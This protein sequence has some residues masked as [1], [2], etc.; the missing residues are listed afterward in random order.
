M[1]LFATMIAGASL[2]AMMLPLPAAAETTLNLTF[3]ANQNDEDYDGAMVFKNYVETNTNGSV[4]VDVFAGAQLCGSAV[5]CFESLKAGVVDIYNGTAGGAAVIYP[6][7]QA[8]DIPYLFS[9]DRVVMDV[10]R[11]PL[12][13]QIRERVLEATNNEIMLLAIGQTGGWRG[14]GTTKKQVKTPADM[15]G[16]KIRTIES[17]IQQTL[18]RNM[19]ASPTPL[20]FSEVYTGLTTGV[21]DGS[22]NS[23]SDIVSA[24]LNEQIKYLTLERN[25]YMTNMW[26]IGNTKFQSLTEEEKTVVLDGAH[27]FADVTFGVQPSKELAAYQAFRDSGGTIYIPTKEETAEFKKQADPVREWYLGQYGEEGKE[28]LAIIEDDIKQASDKIAAANQ[29]AIA[30][31]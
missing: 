20:P 10:L 30:N 8:L 2:M 24:N 31:Q 4:K 9:S 16:L 23:I 25:A 6:P 15:A 19:G 11:G 3:L 18:V 29:A 7:I 12:E 17:P 13:Q 28:F 22:L 5:E 26:Y 14:I 21:I 27:L 1:K